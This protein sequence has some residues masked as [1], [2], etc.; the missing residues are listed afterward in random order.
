MKFFLKGVINTA[1]NMTQKFQKNQHNQ[2]FDQLLPH[3]L[4]ISTEIIL[5]KNQLQFT[6]IDNKPR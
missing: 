4:A 1:I 2:K 5:E 6:T 3:K